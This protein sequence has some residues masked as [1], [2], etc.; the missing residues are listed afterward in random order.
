[1]STS[2]LEGRDS[3]PVNDSSKVVIFNPQ[4]H[5]SQHLLYEDNDLEVFLSKHPKGAYDPEGVGPLQKG[6]NS[7]IIFWDKL[8]NKKLEMFV[9]KQQKSVMISNTDKEE[10]LQSCVQI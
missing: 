1:M 7:I 4:H 10:M 9:Q 3:A 8:H 5:S 6:N 2:T